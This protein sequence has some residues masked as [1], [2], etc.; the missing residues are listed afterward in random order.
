MITQ[1]VEKIDLKDFRPGAESESYEK[2]ITRAFFDYR[3][4][5]NYCFHDYYQFNE[6]SP[7]IKFVCG[8]EAGLTSSDVIDP[9]VIRIAIAMLQKF[10]SCDD[11]PSIYR[12]CGWRLRKG[13]E[14]EFSDTLPRLYRIG[15]E[16]FE[17]RFSNPQECLVCCHEKKDEIEQDILNERPYFE[18]I[19]E[20]SV[21]ESTIHKHVIK[22]MGGEEVIFL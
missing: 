22:C 9:V 4:F 21:A 5:V 14:K 13:L 8:I 2:R 10:D 20:Y 17:G 15:R 1:D 12:E 3:Q 16:I 11:I 18:I 7:F 6:E 19:R